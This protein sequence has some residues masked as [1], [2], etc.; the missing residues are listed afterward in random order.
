MDVKI[1][2][3]IA[4]PFCYIGKKN[5]SKALAEFKSD[6]PVNIEY[7][8]YELDNQAPKVPTK[9]MY[10]VLAGKH[11]K[12]E[13]EIREMVAQIEAQGEIAGIDFN[14]DKVIPASTRDAHR[15]L[16]LSFEFGV[17]DEVLESLHSAYFIEGK[18]VSDKDVLLEVALKHNIPEK[19][20]LEVID[21]PSLFLENVIG[22]FNTAKVNGV[23]TLPYYIF[24]EKFAISGAREPRHYTIALNKT[25][26]TKD[27]PD[28]G[29][30]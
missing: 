16:K 24:D 13:S 9:N 28:N 1:Y 27:A 17:G 21:D 11:E 18:N 23:R 10:E 4:C 6:E 12:P 30:K 2:I 25:L 26:Q 19:A 3:D 8:S 7:G 14:M 22:D 15:L 29:N 20:A 5:F